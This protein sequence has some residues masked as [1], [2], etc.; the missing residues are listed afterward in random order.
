MTADTVTSPAG[1]S[2][3]DQIKI[4]DAATLFPMMG[5]AELDALAKDIEK[6]GL[7]HP[8]IFYCD[9][10][11]KTRKDHPRE[12]EQVLLDGR[13]RLAAMELAGIAL[14]DPDTGRLSPDVDVEGHED[15][16]CI[17]WRQLDGESKVFDPYAYV[18][19]ANLH[20]RHLTAEQKREVGRDDIGVGVKDLRFPV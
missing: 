5:D 18:V 1:Q 7:R 2:W 3:R 16:V 12:D 11:K 17:I 13:N 20:R 19:S 8:L 15:P 10:I 9:R 14:S 4:H 6:N